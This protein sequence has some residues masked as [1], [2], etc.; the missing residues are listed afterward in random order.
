MNLKI[1]NISKK[2]ISVANTQFNFIYITM[3]YFPDNV[4]LDE[5]QEYCRKNFIVSSG[6]S[7]ESLILS[8]DKPVTGKYLLISSMEEPLNNRILEFKELSIYGKDEHFYKY[9]SK[10]I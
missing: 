4:V 9:E 10:K 2:S 8:C 5:N 1:I 6:V 7:S 3:S